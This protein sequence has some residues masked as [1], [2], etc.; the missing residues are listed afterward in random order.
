MTKLT[1][2]SEQELADLLDLPLDKARRWLEVAKSISNAAEIYK[3]QIYKGQ[4]SLSKWLELESESATSLQRS[5]VK[6]L[7]GLSVEE[8][9]QLKRTG[10][11]YRRFPYF[12]RKAPTDADTRLRYLRDLL[13]H[14]SEFQARY[15][16]AYE[17][18][19]G[20]S[21]QISG[22]PLPS[23]GVRILHHD[24]QDQV[25]PAGWF[26]EW[27]RSQNSGDAFSLMSVGR[28]KGDRDKKVDQSLAPLDLGYMR[29]VLLAILSRE[30][31]EERIATELHDE[32]LR[33]QLGVPAQ[34]S[35][36]ITDL[37][38]AMAPDLENSESLKKA[39]RPLF[40]SLEKPLTPEGVLQWKWDLLRGDEKT[41]GEESEDTKAKITRV[42]FA[43]AALLLFLD[44][45]MPGIEGARSLVLT[46]QIVKLA[47]IIQKVSKSLNANAN[48]LEKLLAFRDP[49]HP[50]T[51]G[52]KFYDVLVGYRMGEELETLARSSRITPYKSSP[53]ESGGD[54][55]GG[56]KHWK[57]RLAEKLE[58]GAEIEKEKYP[59]ATAVFANR[60]KPRIMAKARLAFHAY[61]DE[62][63][64]Q[65]PS[66]EP[67]LWPN[68]GSKINVDASTDSGL[69]V[70]QAYVQV[71]SC[72]EQN[73]N[74]FP[75]RSD[76]LT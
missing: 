62:I 11:F 61:R 15:P 23:F 71:G 73:L 28:T 40:G 69:E 25:L 36:R 60:Y 16:A 2:L 46:E 3:S 38:L 6:E 75:T 27:K 43:A 12:K 13:R 58:H 53:S 56:T 50:S 52:H 54:D 20:R 55:H 7:M 57:I 37:R 47:E 66:E 59:L 22:L 34:A 39:L 19:F 24:P 35:V 8:V 76:L 17:L 26:Q 49:N 9:K 70:V 33:E 14:E 4:P 1:D 5:S 63:F 48:K 18:L 65:P 10:E 30:E 41:N 64:H 51:H 31:Y 74:P 32:A 67:R 45:D 29:G 44:F 21:E 68:T 42:S 72:L